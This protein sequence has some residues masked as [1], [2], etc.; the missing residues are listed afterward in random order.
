MTTLHLK[1]LRYMLYAF[2]FSLFALEHLAFSS[3]N[4]RRVSPTTAP[5]KLYHWTTLESAAKMFADEQNFFPLKILEDSKFTSAQ[6][7]FRSRRGLFSWS[8]PITGLALNDAE[9]HG[10]EVLFEIDLAPS[11]KA[12]QIETTFTSDNRF[13]EPGSQK[14]E[15][16]MREFSEVDVIKHVYGDA[17]S[18]LFQEWILI[19]KRNISK[20]HADPTK[21][22]PIIKK[23]LAKLRDPSFRYEPFELFSFVRRYDFSQNQNAEMFFEYQPFRVSLADFIEKNYITDQTF[24]RR[25]Y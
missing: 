4:N 19:S 24:L 8:H 15:E 6:G 16:E 21:L 2:V 3:P 20:V 12:V 17:A 11:T 22:Y 23:E 25:E 5:T 10:G 1:G 14:V 13:L 18:P 9:I 7:A